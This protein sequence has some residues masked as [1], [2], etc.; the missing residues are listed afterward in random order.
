MK[1]LIIG[2]GRVGSAL[3]KRLVD[4][5]WQV[6]VVDESEE[7]LG[8]LGEGWPGEF[9]VGHALE[10][11]VL[12]GAGIRDADAVIA[13]TDGDNTNIVVAQVAKLR[14][15]VPHVAARILDPARAEFY[16]GRGFD[17]VSPT[18]TAIEELTNSALGSQPV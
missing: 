14:Y 3:A 18:G 6:V 4:V 5:G 17:V 2:S 12:E 11:Q 13:A 8:R 7:A 1:A 16:S 15:E 9:H 10:I